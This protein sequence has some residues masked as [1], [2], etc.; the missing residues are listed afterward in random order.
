MLSPEPK[1]IPIHLLLI[2]A[3]LRNNKFHT[4]TQLGLPVITFIVLSNYSIETFLG[5]DFRQVEWKNL[6]GDYALGDLIKVTDLHSALKAIDEIVKEGEGSS[7]SN[8]YNFYKH[9]AQLSHYYLFKCLA[10]KHQLRA[11]K[12]DNDDMIQVSEEC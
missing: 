9:K 3:E 11:Y 4:I 6:G 1:T 2:N 7:A 10:E 5:N 12:E 8:P